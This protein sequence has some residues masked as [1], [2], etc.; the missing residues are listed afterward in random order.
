VRAEPLP[1][2][3]ATRY[4]SDSERGFAPLSS[5]PM[6]EKRAGHPEPKA[7]FATRIGI[8][9]LNIG[10]EVPHFMDWRHMRMYLVYHGEI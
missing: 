3:T 5:G 10:S 4:R 1:V 8:F 9:L 6:N 7:R 2:D